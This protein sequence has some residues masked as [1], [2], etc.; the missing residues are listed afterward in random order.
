MAKKSKHKSKKSNVEKSAAAEVRQSGNSTRRPDWAV[1]ILA[2]LGCALTAGLTWLK[3]NQASLPYCDAGS[4]CDVVQNS[5]W[6]I[7]FGLPIAAWGFFTYLLIA[8]N[9]WRSATRSKAWRWV[10]FFATIGLAVSLYLTAVS[11]FEIKSVCVYCLVSLGLMGAIFLLVLLRAQRPQFAGWH[12][13]SAVVG[14]GVIAFLFLHFAGKFDPSAGPEDPYLKAL[15]IH[16]E[17]SGAKFYGAYW[18]PHCQLQKSAFGASGKRLPYV[19]CTPSGPKGPR[20]TDC[21]TAEIAGYPTW[22]IGQRR[23]ERAVAPVQ[24][25]KLSRFEP[26]AGLAPPALEVAE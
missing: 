24:L 16:L 4:G 26:P 10:V 20:A 7:L 6:S 12:L 14:L 13:G 25:A 22:I 18:C 23:I 11:I 19:E 9:G 1:L 3:M 17:Q 21:L 8:I 2:L 5:R 15:A